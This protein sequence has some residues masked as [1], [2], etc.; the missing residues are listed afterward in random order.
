MLKCRLLFDT[1]SYTIADK[2][3]F[4]HGKQCIID[5]WLTGGAVVHT[6]RQQSPSHMKYISSKNSVV[7]KVKELSILL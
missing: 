1:C 7:E 6:S 3:S 2:H 5:V 4:E